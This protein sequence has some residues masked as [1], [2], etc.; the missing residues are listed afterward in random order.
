M[1][2]NCLLCL[3]ALCLIACET[4]VEVDV[5]RYPA[6]LT[7]NSSF[8]PD[9]V[10]RVELTSNRYILDNA[11]FAAI[12]DAE[13]Q[14]AGPDGASIPLTYQGDNPYTG[15]SI[16]R[17]DGSLP[18][19]NTPY[20]LRVS[21][22]TLGSL[23]AHGQISDSPVPIQNVFWDTTDVRTDAY[24]PAGRVTYGVTV[25][26]DDP[27]EEN[28]YS[29]SILFT[30]A[31]VGERDIDRDGNPEYVTVDFY[32]GFVG[33]QSDDP[34]VDNP[35][36]GSRAEL[37]FK[38]VSFNGRQ[39]VLKLYMTQAFGLTNGRY[40]D[41]FIPFGPFSSPYA[42]DVYDE[43]GNLLYLKGSIGY[44]Y[45]LYAVLRAVT[46]EYYNYNYTRD[47]QA[48]VENNPFAQPVQMFDNVE[49]GLGI[50]AGYSQV[51]KKV[52]IK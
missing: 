28:Y 2:N 46:E 6:Q 25:A 21:H 1:R 50:F 40:L 29:L 41:S 10:W 47:L 51:E 26:L 37:L 17:A 18:R 11:P 31:P 39:Y 33:I 14:V 19:T 20:T 3:L 4:A 5:P 43:V 45:R 23:T 44:R 7:V 22:P 24:T 42:Y 35:F 52:T 49:G 12:T 32:R 16:Y 9:S 30:D 27:P 38:D 13:V 15:N 36:L 34:I 8:T 48:S